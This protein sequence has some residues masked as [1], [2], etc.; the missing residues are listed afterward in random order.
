MFL[1]CTEA[2]TYILIENR[3]KFIPKYLS[4]CNKFH[5]RFQTKTLLGILYYIASVM[6]LKVLF[7]RKTV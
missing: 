1:I 4:K 7:S 5:I 6:R 3:L 2:F